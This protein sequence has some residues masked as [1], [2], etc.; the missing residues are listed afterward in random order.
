MRHHMIYLTAFV[1]FLH[2]KIE[3]SS[4]FEA[5]RKHLRLVTGS[6][7]EI[8]TSRSLDHAARILTDNEPGEGEP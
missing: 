6:A 3:F 7:E 5:P 2:E 1:S 4:F 8:D